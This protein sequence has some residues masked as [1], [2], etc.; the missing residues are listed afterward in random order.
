MAIEVLDKGSTRVVLT[1]TSDRIIALGLLGLSV[2][3]QVLF[4]Y[5]TPL[6]PAEFVAFMTTMTW[7]QNPTPVKSVYPVDGDVFSIGFDFD[8]PALGFSII[9]YR[10]VKHNIP[11][12]PFAP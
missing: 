7:P 10:V 8:S 4:R 12:A 3:P 6:D 9:V 11:V 1:I 2:G 5:D